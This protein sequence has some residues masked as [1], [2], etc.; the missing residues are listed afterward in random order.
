M[1][2]E[3]YP[4]IERFCAHWKHAPMLQQTFDA[5]KRSFRDGNDTS[6]D[7]CKGLVECACQVIIES[8]DDPVN[9]LKDWKDS[10]I[11]SETPSL[12][13]W[14]SA[15]VKILDIT[16]S[17]DDPLNKVISQH[18]KLI[19]ELGKFRNSAGPV[20]HG[21]A[22]FVHRL[23]VH[24]QRA[25]VLAADALITFLHEAY[26]EHEPDPINT[27]EPYERFALSNEIIDRHLELQLAIESDGWIEVEALLPNGEVLTVTAESS[28]F[29]F[30]VD[31]EA[32][33][34]ALAVCREAPEPPADDQEIA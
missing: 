2:S 30:G 6:I 31:R 13:N 5:L 26:L 18:F 9:P 16:E 12:G 14:V 10:P 32:Y 7:A 33:K 34:E 22:G 3:W 25:A 29:L 4:G 21:K 27:R 23:S 17:R 24:H 20:S 19:E 1:D 15:T 11:K 28:R 8:L